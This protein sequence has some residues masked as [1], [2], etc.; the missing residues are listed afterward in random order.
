MSNRLVNHYLNQFE[1]TLFANYRVNKKVIHYK[2]D[3][4]NLEIVAPGVLGTT[5]GPLKEPVS[6]TREHQELVG[7]KGNEVI[8]TIPEA[9][10]SFNVS[11]DV[12]EN[13]YVGMSVSNAFRAVEE[14]IYQYLHSQLMEIVTLPGTT[15]KAIFSEL[16]SYLNQ[17]KVLYLT[18]YKSLNVVTAEKPLS[19]QWPVTIDEDAMRFLM[20]NSAELKLPFNEKEYEGEVELGGLNGKKV[21]VPVSELWKGYHY[22]D[23]NVFPHL[24]NALS[25]V[26]NQLIL[27]LKE[28]VENVPQHY[29]P[30]EFFTTHNGLF[31]KH[32]DQQRV[33]IAEIIRANKFLYFKNEDIEAWIDL[34]SGHALPKKPIQWLGA[35]NY[36]VF[37]FKD[38]A[39]KADPIRLKDN[40]F[41]YIQFCHTQVPWELLSEHIVL[42]NGEPL[43]KKHSNNSY[44]SLKNGKIAMNKINHLL[45]LCEKIPI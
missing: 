10:C 6:R 28:L 13:E 14:T 32:Y 27:S 25:N 43:G 42:K 12:K 24:S 38:I 26:I 22:R 21:M 33:M 19:P 18:P 35:I 15:Q 37:W 3:S 36:L 44:E 11:A 2:D 39:V 30:G 9:F 5:E 20:E 23:E 1:K 29:N 8:F 7:Y 34:I 17:K 31:I 40:E 4:A 16:L 45:V 41:N